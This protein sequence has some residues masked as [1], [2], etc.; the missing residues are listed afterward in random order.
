M[1]I[2][3]LIHAQI[4]GELQNIL[5]SLFQW[6]MLW[7]LPRVPGGTSDTQPMPM[8]EHIRSVLSVCIACAQKKR[9]GKG[10]GKMRETNTLS[11]L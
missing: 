10:R 4:R 2:K 8:R 6:G 7:S 1:N 5:M 11:N 3:N 9:K